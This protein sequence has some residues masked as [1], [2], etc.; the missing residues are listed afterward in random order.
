MRLASHV[1]VLIM[2][3]NAS[4]L[5]PGARLVSAVFLSSESALNIPP[6]MIHYGFSKTAV[7]AIAR[8]LAKRA[9]GTRVTVNAL[10]SHS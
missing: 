4:G 1:A 9:A 10:P 7:L 3:A 8:G 6:E 5:R 2:R